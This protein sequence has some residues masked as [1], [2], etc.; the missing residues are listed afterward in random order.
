M[1]SRP[2]QKL[3]SNQCVNTIH[4]ALCQTPKYQTRSVSDSPYGRAHVW[5]R[6]RP[7]LPN[8]I[9]P[10]FPQR[11]IQ[12]DG[13]TFVHYITSPKST[14]WLTRDLTNNPLW[15]YGAT[16]GRFEDDEGSAGR[17]GRFRRKFEELSGNAD[18][19]VEDADTLPADTST[20]PVGKNEKKGNKK[21]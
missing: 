2:L 20:P 15:N 7:K 18:W 17:M 13:S 21:S 8:P 19:I 5:K 10:I 9:V 11:V 3:P 1:F 14:I 12:S 16:G 6:R 4:Y